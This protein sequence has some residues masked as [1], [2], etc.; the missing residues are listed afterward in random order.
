VPC[1]VASDPIWQRAN[2]CCNHA[3]RDRLI[4]A[5]LNLG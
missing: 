5:V 1:N 3:L 2:P 4:G